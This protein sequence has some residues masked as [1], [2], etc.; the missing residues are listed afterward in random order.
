[1]KKPSP[2]PEAVSAVPDKSLIP[3]LE[4]LSQYDPDFARAYSLCGVP[5]VRSQLGGFEGLVNMIISQQIS[6][7]AAKSIRDRLRNAV[8]DLSAERVLNLKDED[9]KAIGL[10]RPKQAYIRSLAETVQGGGLDFSAFDDMED[11]AIVKALTAV[12]GIGR[13]TAE[14]YLLFVLERPDVFPAADL[15]LQASFA[16]LKGLDE[17]P[18]E[19]EIRGL[20]ETWRPW[21]SAGARFLWHHYRHD[22]V[23]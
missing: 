13:W 14:I 2:N 22:A 3:A 7:H 9:L 23:A 10:S 11:E 17:R 21:R 15:A 18:N 20:V 12:K 4:A 8:P 1:M 5:P 16:R 19:K 6:I